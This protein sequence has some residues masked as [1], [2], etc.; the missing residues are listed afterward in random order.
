MVLA[1]SEAVKDFVDTEPLVDFRDCATRQWP[2]VHMAFRCVSAI[3]RLACVSIVA[4]GV[5]LS[6]GPAQAQGT[7]DRRGAID[8][9]S[10]TQSGSVKLPGVVISVSDDSAR[11]TVQQVSDENGHFELP[12]LPPGR[13]RVRATLDG[14]DTVETT[15]TV[16]AGS[17]VHL[18]FDLMTATLAEH[19]GGCAASP[20]FESETLATSE[21]VNASETQILA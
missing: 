6:A 20:A 11:E 14:F 2:W 17:T 7:T 5:A 9:T 16:A 19:A 10:S 18:P 4:M 3:A 12:D 1:S 15:A 13:Y 8:G 21:T